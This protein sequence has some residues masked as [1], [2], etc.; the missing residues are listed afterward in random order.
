MSLCHVLP[1]TFLQLLRKYLTVLLLAASQYGRQATARKGLWDCS[2]AVNQ[3][4]VRWEISFWQMKL[5]LVHN[6]IKF[7]NSQHKT[8]N[9]ICTNCT[10]SFRDA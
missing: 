1:K 2:H 9:I 5:I 6:I 10:F 8:L 4:Q 7:L 3:Q